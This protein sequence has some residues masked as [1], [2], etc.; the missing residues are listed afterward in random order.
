MTVSTFRSRWG[1][2]NVTR[3][4][5]AMEPE[6]NSEG[7]TTQNVVTFET[8]DQTE[9]VSIVGK[10]LFRCED[11]HTFESCYDG[12]RMTLLKP[13]ARKVYGLRL[14]EGFSPETPLIYC[15]PRGSPSILRTSPHGLPHLHPQPLRTA[16]RFLG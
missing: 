16:A 6:T 3:A 1:S 5:M 10:T 2:Y 15:A 11:G 13:Q 7:T 8:T 12:Q 14:K 9:T 4:V